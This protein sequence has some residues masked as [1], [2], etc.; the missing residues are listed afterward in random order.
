MPPIYL[1][2]LLIFVDMDTYRA[3]AN[4]DFLEHQFAW[5][6]E[7]TTHDEATSM[8]W[9]GCYYYGRHTYFEFMNPEATSWAPRDGMAFGVDEAQQSPLIENMLRV[10]GHQQVRR[11]SRSRKYNN[12]DIPWFWAVEIPRPDTH[13]LITWIMAYRPEFLI[14]WEP[15][16]PPTPTSI[17]RDQILTRYRT[18]VGAI[19]S[20]SRLFQDITSVTLSLPHEEASLLIH[21]LTVYDYEAV[22]SEGQIKYIGP[23][24]D[25]IIQYRE[26]LPAGIRA[27][28]MK[29]EPLTE[30]ATYQFSE[31]CCLTIY[32]HGEA[33]WRLW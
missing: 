15:D 6:E 2:H 21:E 28:T 33:E 4:S 25:L 17:T 31:T 7:R 26:E 29:T 11:Y 8:S 18:R 9:T 5:F 32:K 24:V 19:D 12:L 10:H 1:N 22:E 23:D 16:L 20:S 27:F 14:Q 13:H 3:I 30:P